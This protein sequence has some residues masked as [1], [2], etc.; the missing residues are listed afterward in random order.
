MVTFC[1]WLAV[2]RS[3]CI[4]RRLHETRPRPVNRNGS[5]SVSSR[6]VDGRCLLAVVLP[7]CWL[8]GMAIGTLDVALIWYHFTLS[9]FGHVACTAVCF[10][11]NTIFPVT[12]IVLSYRDV[13]RLFV[14]AARLLVRSDRRHSS[15]VWLAVRVTRRSS[16]LSIA[17][18]ERRSVS[19]ACD[20]VLRDADTLMRR[21]LADEVC[22][23][24]LVF[25]CGAH[26]DVT[27]QIK[28]ASC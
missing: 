26:C 1:V 23:S 12:V 10:I 2:S 9:A 20:V 14:L 6:D 3:V 8:L 7:A 19:S 16:R 17:S 27:S 22:T 18:G 15:L 21:P 25:V 4:R 28:S 5:V 13:S 24:P 11:V